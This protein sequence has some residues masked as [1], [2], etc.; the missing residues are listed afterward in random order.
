[1]LVKLDEAL[2][3]LVAKPVLSRGH[4][5][6]SVPG[7]GW[8]GY[9]DAKLWPLVVSERAYFITTD[10]GFGD[11]RVYPPGSHAGILV[12][13]PAIESIPAFSEL[14]EGLLQRHTL[15]S[16]A[17]AVTVATAGK[18]RIRRAPGS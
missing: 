4:E 1:M 16:L 12:L 8:G 11:L 6:K 15:E 13:R 5:V 18:V 10:K 17:G 3:V 9:K 2:T 7:Q 14:L